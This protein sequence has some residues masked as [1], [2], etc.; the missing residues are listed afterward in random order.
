MTVNTRDI[1]AGLIFIAIGIL[2]GLGS[3]G[4][5]IG[6]ALRMG[7]GYFPLV[8]AGLLVG[9]GLVILAHGLGHPTTGGLAIPWRGL[10]LILVAP[11]VF[12]FTIR[13]LGL[14]PAVM[15]VVLI[16]AFASQRMSMLLA[17]VLS[18]ALTLFCV[19]VF[20]FGLGLPLRLFGPWLVG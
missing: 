3:I 15:L 20:S 1:G 5:E 10:V 2:F 13:G 8:L 19:L 7:P 14:V 9:L 18:V 4:L 16:S 17:L 6:T 12:G 11:V